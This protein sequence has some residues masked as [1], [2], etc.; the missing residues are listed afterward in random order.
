[1][2]A[3]DLFSDQMHEEILEICA[4]VDLS[5]ELLDAKGELAEE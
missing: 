3:L 4:Q 1:L 2:Q 5:L